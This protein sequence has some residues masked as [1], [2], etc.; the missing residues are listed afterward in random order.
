MSG[1]W[2]DLLGTVKNTFKISTAVLDASS[3]GNVL[4]TPIVPV[5]PVVPTAK[6][7]IIPDGY[8]YIVLG[9]LTLA[10]TGQLTIEGDATLG[11]LGV[12]A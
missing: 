7:Y 12:Y 8:Q 9:Q 3:G 1:I 6:T 4:I 5:K 2:S 11:I 10:G